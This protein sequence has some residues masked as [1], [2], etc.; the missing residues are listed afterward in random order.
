MPIDIIDGFN[1]SKAVPID[2]VRTIKMTLAERDAIP[3]T[4]RYEGMETRVI[5]TKTKYVLEGGIANAN[6]KPMVSSSIPDYAFSS[7]D[8]IRGLDVSSITGSVNVWLYPN[9]IY[10]WDAFSVVADNGGTVLK[11]VGIAE[12]EAGRFVFKT[13]LAVKNHSHTKEELGIEELD[14]SVFVHKMGD[15]TIEGEKVFSDTI[16]MGYEATIEPTEITGIITLGVSE[17]PWDAYKYTLFNITMNSSSTDNIRDF[18]EAFDPS[19]NY[20]KSEN[21]IGFIDELEPN[22]LGRMFQVIVRVGDRDLVCKCVY[23]SYTTQDSNGW[24]YFSGFLFDENGIHVYASEIGVFDEQSVQIFLQNIVD[25]KAAMIKVNDP[26]TDGNPINLRFIKSD[27]SKF[28]RQFTFDYS[29]LRI[30]SKSKNYYCNDS[31]GLIE[32]IITSLDFN[33]DDEITL[34]VKNKREQNNQTLNEVP[35]Y[36][37]NADNKNDFVF[38]TVIRG[39][40]NNQKYIFN[41][42]VDQDTTNS[43]NPFSKVLQEV[44][45]LK[46]YKYAIGKARVSGRIVI[47]RQYDT[48]AYFDIEEAFGYVGQIRD[49]IVMPD[50][51]NK[52]T[53]FFISDYGIYAIRESNN[54]TFQTL[55]IMNYTGNESVIS[56][57]NKSVGKTG[58]L[59]L[60]VQNQKMYWTTNGADIVEIA[61]IIDPNKGYAS[62]L[63]ASYNGN[64]GHWFTI[65]YENGYGFDVYEGFELYESVPALYAYA[66]IVEK[67]RY[68]SVQE[69]RIIFHD[70][71]LGFT[72]LDAPISISNSTDNFSSVVM[73]DGYIYS[74]NPTFDYYSKFN[75]K[76]N[77]VINP[78]FATYKSEDQ[79]TLRYLNC[80]RWV[81]IAHDDY[82]TRTDT[83]KLAKEVKEISQTTNSLTQTVTDLSIHTR[84]YNEGP[85]SPDPTKSQLIEGM[86]TELVDLIL[87][88]KIPF[89]FLSQT[90]SNLYFVANDG[91]ELFYTKM[92]KASS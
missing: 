2:T 43:L 17:T 44:Y 19:N 69:S 18:I 52:N 38:N 25:E 59:I 7:I 51:S 80:G 57:Y 65:A 76:R 81:V 20:A 5:A 31:Y 9:V 74:F 6:W 72:D 50:A 23:L 63:G 68:F 45:S 79:I 48:V 54:G 58:L 37:M 16:Q 49:S 86:S 15:E 22:G 33:T 4:V 8:E 62:Y 83:N 12:G 53:I 3:M 87:D 34:R 32:R 27:C 14:D 30:D 47:A 13:E 71:K 26:I 36:G 21:Y 40:Q 28:S 82:F 39:Q 67:Y 35:R 11:P 1:V 73:N 84:I 55:K 24:A 89:T 42:Y 66:D 10:E 91:A 90:T 46:N 85:S 77:E 64:L 56:Y 78:V 61:G 92:T 41:K 60:D 88:K 70:T 29:G 75:I